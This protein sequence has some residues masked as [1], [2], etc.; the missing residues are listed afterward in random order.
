MANRKMHM[1][2]KGKGM[3]VKPT[4]TAIYKQRVAKPEPDDIPKRPRKKSNYPKG[5]I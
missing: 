3:K 4:P 2:G 5:F 1:G